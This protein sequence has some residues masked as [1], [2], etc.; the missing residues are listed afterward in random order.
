MFYIGGFL[1]LLK[2]LELP[3][4]CVVIPGLSPTL[5]EYHRVFHHQV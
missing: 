1:A 4:G 3:G 2:L 5:K